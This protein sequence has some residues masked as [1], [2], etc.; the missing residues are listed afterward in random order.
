LNDNLLTGT[1]AIGQLSALTALY[2]NTNQLTGT[3]PTTL[4]RLT[5]LLLLCADYMS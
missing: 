5:A 4:G 2:L 3:I 1:I